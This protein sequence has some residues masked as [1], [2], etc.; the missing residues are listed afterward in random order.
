MH[1]EIIIRNFKRRD[2]LGGVGVCGKLIL[3]FALK[4]FIA[5]LDWIYVVVDR[6]EWRALCM[7]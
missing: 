5:G 7:L 2:Y 1:T 4:K 3:K 6:I